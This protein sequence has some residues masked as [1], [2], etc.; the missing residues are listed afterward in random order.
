MATAKSRRQRWV[1]KL[2]DKK[3][4]FSKEFSQETASVNNSAK[5]VRHWSEGHTGESAT[6]EVHSHEDG[7]TGGTPLKEDAKCCRVPSQLNTWKGSGAHSKDD[8]YDSILD[9]LVYQER[10]GLKRTARS[11]SSPAVLMQLGTLKLGDKWIAECATHL[12]GLLKAWPVAPKEA[13]RWTDLELNGNRMGDKGLSAV[14]DMLERHQV[15]IRRARLF[16]NNLTDIGIKRLADFICQQGLMLEE[17]HLSHNQLTSSAVV[18]LCM[19]VVQHRVKLNAK[20][21]GLRPGCWIRLERNQINNPGRVVKLIRKHAQ[22]KICLATDLSDCGPKRCAFF[23][24]APD[25]HLF[26]PDSEELHDELRI[27][28]ISDI[29]EE[30]NNWKDQ[31]IDRAQDSEEDREDSQDAELVSVQPTSAWPVLLGSRNHMLHSDDAIKPLSKDVMPPSQGDQLSEDAGTVRYEGDASCSASGDDA[32]GP[33]CAG[34]SSASTS[35]G[36]Q[37]DAEE[38][39]ESFNT[40]DSLI[41]SSRSKDAVIA[42][43]PGLDADVLAVTPA[44]W[45]GMVPDSDS[46]EKEEQHPSAELT[47]GIEAGRKLLSMLMEKAPERTTAPHSEPQPLSTDEFQLWAMQ[48]R[49]DKEIGADVMNAETFGDDSGDGW[50]FEENLAANEVIAAYHEEVAQAQARAA[51]ELASFYGHHCAHEDPMASYLNC[52]AHLVAEIERL[53]LATRKAANFLDLKPACL[54]TVVRMIVVKG[55]EDIAW[56]NH[57]T[58]LHLAAEL[59]HSSVMPLLVALGADPDD[60]DAKGRTA[61]DVAHNH[62][63][64]ECSMTLKQIMSKPKEERSFCVSRRSSEACV[65][66]IVPSRAHQIEKASTQDL[67]KEL[68]RLTTVLHEMSQ[69]LKVEPPCMQDALEFIT[70]GH[71]LPDARFRSAYALHMAAEYGWEDI[72]LYLLLLRV[73]PHTVDSMGRAPID[74]AM[75]S[76]N[77]GCVHMLRMIMTGYSLAEIANWADNRGDPA[78]MMGTEPSVMHVRL[79]DMPPP[80]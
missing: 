23:E 53:D 1:P 28:E 25:V 65:N 46:E 35:G 76:R 40:W 15:S 10:L 80:R 29:L 5:Y 42:P 38:L 67:K 71:H 49:E 50:S 4:D 39:T 41:E 70:S 63:H 18:H 55:W 48:A 19:A 77:W 11:N 3:A 20:G 14:I 37:G 51:A 16:R 58:A 44:D 21:A 31:F 36:S 43:P 30:I 66:D 73:D 52:Q 72:L 60:V 78:G 27:D 7:G 45:L 24:G 74:V 6:M 59:G 33:C 22:I 54:N 57:Y 64:W 32:S 75:W 2:N 12:D 61:L 34:T 62:Q 17:L 79:R 56:R 13:P 9:N 47:D 68:H 26:M 8:G 69:F